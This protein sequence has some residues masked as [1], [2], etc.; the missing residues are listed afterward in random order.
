[1]KNQVVLMLRTVYK[2]FL[3]NESSSSDGLRNTIVIMLIF[4]KSGLVFGNIFPCCQAYIF[5]SWME[6]PVFLDVID[7]DLL[8]VQAQYISCLQRF[9]LEISHVSLFTVVLSNCSLLQL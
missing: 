7:S 4:F 3:V 8:S 5:F 9:R 2:A 6:C 1:M